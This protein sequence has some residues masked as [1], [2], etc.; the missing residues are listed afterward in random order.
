MLRSALNFTMT[1]RFLKYASCVEHTDPYWPYRHR[2]AS[3]RGRVTWRG[4][5]ALIVKLHSLLNCFCACPDLQL[6][7]SEAICS[8]NPAHCNTCW[9]GTGC[10]FWM[11]DGG[12]RNKVEPSPVDT[13]D[14]WLADPKLNLLYWCWLKLNFT[15]CW[16]KHLFWHVEY[17]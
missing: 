12:E 6:K 14:I 11:E 5:Q 3:S 16:K 17:C 1:L 13:P 10:L 2:A 9:H 4:P 15:S 7:I 8:V